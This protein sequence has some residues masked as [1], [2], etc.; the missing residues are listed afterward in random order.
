MSFACV[1]HAARARLL[2][3][4]PPVK[5]AAPERKERRLSGR[6]GFLRDVMH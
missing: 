4:R 2:S 5:A 1:R 6:P 3:A